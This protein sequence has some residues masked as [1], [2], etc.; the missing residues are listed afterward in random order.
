MKII[1]HLDHATQTQKIVKS[2]AFLA[3]VAAALVA[4]LIFSSD[5]RAAEPVR[6]DLISIGD[7]HDEV[8]RKM[9]NAPS[10]TETSRT[11]GVV[12]ATMTFRAGFSIVTV[13]LLFDHVISVEVRD[14][15][16]GELFD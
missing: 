16:L 12:L 5:A 11:F 7:S 1:R 3:V 4:A 13:R 10:K 6:A 8:V 15:S 9:G 14:R 2:R